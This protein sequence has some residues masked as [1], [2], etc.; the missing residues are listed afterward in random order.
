M[1]LTVAVPLLPHSQS[2]LIMPVQRIPRYQ[3]L[4]KELQKRTPADHPDM[5]FIQVAARA[6]LNRRKR[7]R[8]SR[9]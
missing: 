2:F 7:W 6:G 1:E 8:S 3:L 5:P 9:R 4:L